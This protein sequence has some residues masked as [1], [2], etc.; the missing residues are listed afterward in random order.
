[1]EGP[2][3]TSYQWITLKL[4]P[5]LHR[6]QVMADYMS[7]FRS[8]QGSLHFNAHAGKI[9][10]EY[11]H[12]WYTAKTRFFG[13]HFTHR[14]HRCIFNCFYV[15]GPNSYRIRRNN[16]KYTAITPFKVIKVADFGTNQ[17]PTCDFL[18]VINTNLLS[19]CILYRFSVMADYWSNFR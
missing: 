15:I 17:K 5:I 19:T 12:K 10:C 13:L 6:F 7:N 11:R 2:Y 3:A 16:A 8:R 9:P 1:M 4:P 14:M 18:L